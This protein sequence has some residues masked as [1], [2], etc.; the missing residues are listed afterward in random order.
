ME[1]FLV[2]LARNTVAALLLAVVVY[3]V[4]RVWRS[5]PVVHVLWLL[6][7]VKLVVPP[8]MGIEW[9]RLVPSARSEN[10]G[11]AII[12]VPER[13]SAEHAVRSTRFA[14]ENTPP[15][16]ERRLPAVAEAAVPTTGHPSNDRSITNDVASTFSSFWERANGLVFFLWLAG[17]VLCAVIT[18]TR[19]ANFRRLLKNTLPASERMQRLGRE[20]A[21]RFNVPGLPDLRYIDAG[22]PFLWCLGRRPVI[23]LPIRLFQQLDDEQVS[24]ILTH[25]LAHLRRRDHWVRVIELVISTVY[26]WNPLVWIVRRQMH[27]AEEQSCDAWVRWAF[28]AYAK[29]YAEVVLLAADSMNTRTSTPPVL[30]SSF[31][32][33][34]SLKARIEMILQSHFAPRISNRSKLVIALLALITLPVF[35]QSTKSQ[36]PKRLDA[37]RPAGGDRPTQL[38]EAET[39]WST[40][41]VASQ[42]L[43]AA[44]AKKFAQV[45]ETPS[46]ADF[47]YVVRF[48]QGASKLLQG[49]KIDITEVRGT[50]ETMTLGNTY[51][52]KGTYTLASHD[53]ASL[54]V[55]VTAASAADATGP[56]LKTQSAVVNKGTGTFKLLYAMICKGSPHVSFYP[57]G[58]GGDFGG[59]YFGT[60]E[61][62]LTHWWG[63]GPNKQF[64][65]SALNDA[66]RQTSVSEFPH[67]VQFERG[68]SRFANGD[69]I[70]I[71]EVRGTAETIIPGHLYSIK[72]TY[73]LASHDRALLCAS[74][75]AAHAAD[76]TATGLKVQNAI[77]DKGEG[78]FTLFLPMSYKGWPHVSFYPA[79]GG[80]GFGGAYFGTGDSVLQQS[81]TE[82]PFRSQQN[83]ESDGPSPKTLAD[84]EILLQRPWDILGLRLSEL[85]NTD[86]RLDPDWQRMR[87]QRL[88][89][90][91]GQEHANPMFHPT[92][93]KY[94]GGLNV[95]NVRPGS[96]AF[97]SDIQPNDILV[98]MER[99]KTLKVKDVVWILD[100]SHVGADP[101]KLRL[102]IVRGGGPIS[103]DVT[104]STQR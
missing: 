63:E 73:T 10:V 34:L 43:R 13:E 95:V 3:G 53:R 98:G 35:A 83:A 2:F 42:S 80:N 28:P 15:Q 23:L 20:I 16:A 17:A 70:T 51:W 76:G 30:A 96:P 60:G 5:P 85:S 41:S 44:V 93:S 82:T 103:V 74:V 88:Q 81:R 61:S 8:M 62:V 58:G 50:A 40:L 12:R 45:P 90:K 36:E 18:I 72:G 69:K 55:A 26:W 56:T 77:V 22:G 71:R 87:W 99:W 86:V 19:I 64:Q 31:L 79:D 9:T 4:T 29:R 48:E 1:P 101:T 54:M 47:P 97:A 25:E 11:R 94:E 68:E 38:P 57:I 65:L 84:D 78:S 27:Q 52:I 75:T 6:V 104:I 37:P 7:L 32:R 66:L 91:D 24:M 102:L 46:A 100:H 21:G 49:D 89:R 92:S 59:A 33:R 14:S 39:K 67:A